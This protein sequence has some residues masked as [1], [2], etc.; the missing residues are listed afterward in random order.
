MVSGAI[1]VSREALSV[2]VPV[3][4]DGLCADVPLV[5]NVPLIDN[6]AFR[7][8]VSLASVPLSCILPPDGSVPVSVKTLLVS[9]KSPFEEKVPLSINIPVCPEPLVSGPLNVNVPLVSQAALS[10]IFPGVARKPESGVEVGAGLANVMFPLVNEPF[11]E[12][13]LFIYALE[14]EA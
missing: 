1:P 7:A 10:P 9:I 3:C 13:T 11:N 5:A 2:N 8:E 6:L 14:P 4:V 12:R